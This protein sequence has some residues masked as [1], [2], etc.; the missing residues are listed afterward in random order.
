MKTLC[1]LAVVAVILICSD[2][3]PV[4]SDKQ[5]ISKMKVIRGRPWHGLVPK[6]DTDPKATKAVAR[7]FDAK[8]DNF[9]SS[10]TKTYK[11]RFWYNDQWYKPGGPQFLMIGGESAENSAWLDSA[12]YE[13]TSIAQ[14]AGAFVFLLEHR[15]YGASQPT[16]DLSFNSLKYLTSEQAL[17]DVKNFILAM[18][19]Q[20]NFTN[21]R[22]I[23]YGGSYSGALSAWARQ[24]YPETIYA[25]VGSSGPVQAVVDF[26][27]YLDV[28]YNALNNYDPK[29]A[30]SVH[31]GFL[32]INDLIKTD[33]GRQTLSQSFSLCNPLTSDSNTVNY[34]YESIIGNYMGIV[35][36]SQDNVADYADTLTIPQLCKQQT[37]ANKDDI[38]GVVAVNNWLMQL[39]GEWCLDVDYKGYIDYLK[40]GTAGSDAGDYRSW[41]WQT[42]NEFGFYQSTDST[43]VT[44]NFTGADIPV[45]YYVQQCAAVYD[46]SLNNATVYANVD[47]TNKYYL[48]Q[49]KYNGT[50]VSLPNGTNDPWHVLGVLKATNSKNYPVI[51]DGTSHCADMYAPSS[52]DKPSLT[53]ARKSVRSH[54]ISWVHE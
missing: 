38:D 39:Y 19:T 15:F 42:C 1:A 34:F 8:V 10:N 9:D 17:A 21:P 16:G 6:P 45:D 26:T 52:N 7:Y 13:W 3:S 47:K 37:Q 2:A 31:T 32:K 44:G 28:V 14:E 35:Q 48:G 24:V 36:Y 54:V 43:L 29:C 20:H 23:T 50:R 4:K 18:N 27:G 12:N 46:A 49:N 51:I 25:A 40:T 30:A 22:W 11:Q 41:V 33:A 5:F 53:A